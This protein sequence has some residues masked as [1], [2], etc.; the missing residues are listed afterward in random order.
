[1]PGKVTTT[2]PIQLN[3]LGQS[4]NDI[5]IV[6]G[7]NEVST[8]LIKQLYTV[9]E[10]SVFPNPASELVNIRVEGNERIVL[11]QVYDMNGR[12][13]INLE[14]NQDDGINISQLSAGMYLLRVNLEGGTVLQK[15]LLK[16]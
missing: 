6:V 12:L 8:G 7:A 5:K 3:G 11:C 2:S 10:W 4:K 15:K 16:E 9:K 13:L 1:M 14:G